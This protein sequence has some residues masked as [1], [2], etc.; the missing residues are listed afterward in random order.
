MGVYVSLLSTRPDSVRPP[1]QSAQRKALLTDLH[2]I[3]DQVGV[4]SET[5]YVACAFSYPGTEKQNGD[6]RLWLAGVAVR[7]GFAWTHATHKIAA[8]VADGVGGTANGAFA[9][10]L[11]VGRMGG[12]V[13]SW[14]TGE[15]ELEAALI[16]TNQAL[17]LAT[18]D[19]PSLVGS[20]TTLVGALL[21][22]SQLSVVTV[23][24]S[25]AWLFRNQM[26]I[27]LNDSQNLD[28]LEANSP[29]TSYFGGVR[30][31]L[32]V[33]TET[34]ADALLPDD[35][36]LLCSD[37]FLKGLEYRAVRTTLGQGGSLVQ[38]GSALAAALRAAYRPDDASVVLIATVSSSTE[39]IEQENE[40][41][42][43]SS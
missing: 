18:S 27:R 38:R 35:V 37:G 43:A 2:P 14:E 20:A 4:A 28:S 19:Q 36:L 26:L 34:A 25:E 15:A 40:T 16:E 17:M 6:D 41:K 33:S 13:A 7:E 23:G 24:D 1:R 31:R 30:P 22:G 8:F 39:I 32:E 21:V 5:V 3:P 9:A 10:E 12:V 42:C 29:I 11:V